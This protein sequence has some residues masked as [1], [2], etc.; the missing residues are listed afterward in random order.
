MIAWVPFDEVRPADWRTTHMLRPDVKV[1]TQSMT[2]FG[3]LTHL[4]VR[5]ADMTIIDGF[6]RWMVAHTDK[7]FIRAHGIEVPIQVVD[8][9][10]I[11]AR[12]MHVMCNRARGAVVARYLA[13]TFQDVLR[14]RKYDEQTLRKML[15]MSSDE[16]E[17][18][19]DASLIKSRKIDE[20]SY[21]KA[22][23]PVEAPPGTVLDTS[24]IE[25]PPNPDR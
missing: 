11:D 17:L 4:V 1:L 10:E 20:Y 6:H 13:S 15:S 19:V 23:V 8:V 22:W 25:R 12:L 18:L 3:W 9:D 5:R 24:N 7:G 14:S 16:F 2:K 21:S